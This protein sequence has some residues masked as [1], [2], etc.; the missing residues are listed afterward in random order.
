MPKEDKVLQK[1]KSDLRAA[2]GFWTPIL[3][4]SWHS[5][6][7]LW[8]WV[9]IVP[10]AVNLV[11][12]IIIIINKGWG[13]LVFLAGNFFGYYCL[14][15]I[16]VLFI[17][18]FYFV[19]TISASNFFEQKR[20]ADRY[21]WNNIDVSYKEIH[22][23]DKLTGYRIRVENDK[24]DQCYFLIKLQYLELDGIKDK[25]LAIEKP[26][27][28]LWVS[29]DNNNRQFGIG[30]RPKS[31]DSSEYVGFWELFKIIEDGQGK[32]Y[33]IIFCEYDEKATQKP[34]QQHALFSRF[35]VGELKFYGAY[36]D[37][38]IG[39]GRVGNGKIYKERIPGNYIYKFRI[40]ITDN[41]PTI[42][43][44]K[45]VPEMLVEKA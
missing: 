16:V 36:V 19:I 29:S 22:E 25:Y 27:M 28:L 20:K 15:F 13:E 3:R 14:A 42:R 4:Q 5:A 33:G 6:W 2:R 37:I 35:A 38:P 21:Y 17:I 24:I 8:L 40:D 41:D 1:I 44:E 11:Q 18:Y 32:K 39:T 23:W 31:L 12:A 26:R 34:I 43:L 9:F 45:C 10:L 30:L 7:T